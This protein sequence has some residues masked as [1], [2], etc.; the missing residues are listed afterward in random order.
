MRVVLTMML[1]WRP[2]RW[3]RR[4]GALS[5]SRVTGQFL[6]RFVTLVLTVLTAMGES[7]RR[8]REERSIN[9]RWQRKS[10]AFLLI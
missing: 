2:H 6:N 8:E 1:R 9:H 10:E 7:A 5:C 3:I 4:R